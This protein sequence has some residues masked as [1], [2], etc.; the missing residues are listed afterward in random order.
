[1]KY[2]K[3]ALI[4]GGGELPLVFLRKA[5]AT[6]QDVLVFEIQGEGNPGLRFFPNRKIKI[7]PMNLSEMISITRSE[8]IK[9]VMFLGYVRPFSLLKN[10]RFDKRTVTAFM[11]LK[12][13]RPGALMRAAIAEFKKDGI[14]AVPTTYLMEEALAKSGFLTGTK[15]DI[16]KV[17]F[18]VDI[19]RKLAGM[20]VGQTVVMGSGMIWAVEAMEGTDNCIKRGG[21]LAKKGFIVIKMA[22]PE[23]DMRYDIPA[24]GLKTLKLINGLGGGGIIVEAGKTF[25][26]K[27]EETV[28]YADRHNL[29]IYGW[30]NKK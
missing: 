26:L 15:A 2:K 22:R 6:G 13:R 3:L 11:G 17:K 4:A 28:K 27:R 30:R 18:G 25:L 8:G 23:Q 20:D 19:T 21:K 14:R 9:H 5:A 1:V 24:I 16:N 12:D 10:I 7:N 29:F